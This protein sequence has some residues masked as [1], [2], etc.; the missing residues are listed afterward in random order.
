MTLHRGSQQTRRRELVVAT[1]LKRQLSRKV[2]PCTVWIIEPSGVLLFAF[3]SEM[4]SIL[5]SALRDHRLCEKTYVA[6]LRGDWDQHYETEQIT[7]DKPLEVHGIAKDSKTVFRKLAVGTITMLSDRNNTTNK[8]SCTLVAASPQTGRTRQ[9]RRHAATSLGMPILGD[10]QHGDSKMNRWWRHQ[11]GLNR[12]AL[13]CLAVKQLHIISS[14]SS[15]EQQQQKQRPPPPSRDIVAPLPDN[16]KSI[17]LQ[18][19]ELAAMWHAAAAKEPLLA[20]EW[21]D[22]RGGTRGIVKDWQKNH[23]PLTDVLVQVFNEGG[24]TTYTTHMNE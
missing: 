18:R 4:A 16:L 12:L 2:S 22:H 17:F 9:I 19:D 14:S 23:A 20:S 1:T 8:T 15:Q 24:L 5:H 3:S 13:H 7:I 6:L 11:I 21:I 10:T